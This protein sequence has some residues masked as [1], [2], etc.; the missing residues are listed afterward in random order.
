MGTRKSIPKETETR[1]LTSSRRRCALCFGLKGDLNEKKGQIA[2]LDQDPSN[3]DFDNLAWLCFDHHDTYDGRTR[4]S[5]NYTIDEVKTHR[6]KLYEEIA[7]N[8]H[9]KFTESPKDNHYD[10]GARIKTVRV[11]LGLKSSQFAELL[12]VGS[13]REYEAI[14]NGS[15]EASLSLLN[16]ISEISGINVEWLKHEEGTRYGVEQIYF[17]PVDDDLKYCTS[18]HPQEYFLTV[19]AKGP[20]HVS[21]VAQTDKYR[22]Q[23]IATGITLDF[24][25]WVEDHWIAPRFYEFLERLSVSWDG[26]EG[27]VLP[28]KYEKLLYDGCIHFLTARRNAYRYGRDLLYDILDVEETRGKP[29]LTYSKAYGGDW[30]HEAHLGYKKILTNIALHKEFEQV[31]IARCDR[32]KEKG[33]DNS[34]IREEIK[35]SHGVFAVK[36]L[37]YRQIGIP[38]LKKLQEL[39]LLEQS[40]EELVI[41]NHFKSLFTDVEIAEARRRLDELGYFKKGK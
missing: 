26:I 24:A 38:Q 40:M 8:K 19:D 28:T 1:V 30:M 20:H 37:F 27:V 34:Y 6:N 15:N 32:A 13:Q 7:E 35:A 36:R 25:D 16:E 29:F 39:G 11:E 22:Y 9:E 18:L 23:V 31:L 10:A 12:S 2:H 17:N 3:P 4:Q 33:F 14:E 5:K 41:Q 21:L